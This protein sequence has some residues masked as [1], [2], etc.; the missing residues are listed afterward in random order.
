MVYYVINEE[1]FLMQVFKKEFI[2]DK[3][4]ALFDIHT[5]EFDIA[6]SFPG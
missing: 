3:A 1:Q 2:M 5:H 6:V 4:P